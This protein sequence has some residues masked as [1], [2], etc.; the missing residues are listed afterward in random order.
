MHVN[1]FSLTN[2]SAQRYLLLAVK[3]SFAQIKLQKGRS[4]FF[5]AEHSVIVES[6]AYVFPLAL[7]LTALTR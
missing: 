3:E 2:M 7:S 4:Y 1:T 6:V 5:Y